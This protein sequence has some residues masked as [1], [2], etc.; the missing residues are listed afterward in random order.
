[1]IRQT[2]FLSHGLYSLIVLYGLFNKVLYNFSQ[3]NYKTDYSSQS[4]TLQFVMNGL[5]NKVLYNFINGTAVGGNQLNDKTDYSSQSGTL[6]FNCHEGCSTKSCT[7]SLMVQLLVGTSSMIKQTISP[8][9]G[10]YSLIVMY[11]LFNKLLYNFSD[12]TTIGGSQLNDKTDYISQ[13]G[14]LQFNCHEW[15]VQQTLVQFQ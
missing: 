3:L 12:G 6:Q 15:V 4:G 2:I 13:S 8:S 7:I 5:F 9:Q 11:G 14:T 1:M 10:L